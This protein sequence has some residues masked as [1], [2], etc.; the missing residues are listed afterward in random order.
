MIRVALVLLAC[1]ACGAAP[2][3]GPAG[4]PPAPPAPASCPAGQFLDEV[5]GGAQHRTADGTVVATHSTDCRPFPPDCAKTP[6]CRCLRD[7]GYM[8]CD[9]DHGVVHVTELR[10]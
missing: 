6:T 9:Q 2:E 10:P 4:T 8:I 1:V 3:R 5:S 7:L